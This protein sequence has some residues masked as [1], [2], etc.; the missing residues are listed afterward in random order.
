MKK[1]LLTIGLLGTIAIPA[2][3]P[4]QLSA[5][6]N[7]SIN[8]TSVVIP[9]YEEK[10]YT[11]DNTQIILISD[12]EFRY[13]GE[14]EEFEGT[15]QKTND[16]LKLYVSEDLFMS[17][18]INNED[19]TYSNYTDTNTNIYTA[20]VVIVESKNGEIYV[21]AFEGNVG[22]LVTITVVPD[23]LYEL[24]SISVNGVILE[25]KID[26][27]G[28]EVYQFQMVE[29]ANTITSSFVV[30]D[31]KLEEIAVLLK[32]IQNKDWKAIFTLD[33]LLKL[34]SFLF[35]LVFGSG[36]FVTMLKYKKIKAKTIED[37][38]DNVTDILEKKI[39]EQLIK[40]LEEF[41]GPFDAKFL[42]KIDGVVEI[43]RVL[44]RCMILMQ[45]GTPEA[46][47][48]ILKEIESIKT[49]EEELSNQVKKLIHDEMEKKEQELHDKEQAIEE[50]K[51]V[52]NSTTTINNSTE[53]LP[54]L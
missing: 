3:K 25:S 33:N 19:G 1:L 26:V 41:F 5:N 36:F 4:M 8:S 14:S 53:E 17:I 52:N 9:S 50:L 46:R 51:E 21:D 10:T 23:V 6:D 40:F 2:M 28:N 54:H 32:N 7:S 24:Q 37:V 16:I 47:I 44:T 29:G 39:P 13:I 11:N 38:N 43:T 42:E 20:N 30:S 15:Y 31:E 34:I 45:E 18:M 35:T 12:T 22:D 27:N 48:A 49:D